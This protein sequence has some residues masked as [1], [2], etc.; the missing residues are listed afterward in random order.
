V[1]GDGAAAHL[2]ALRGLVDA[3]TAT[4]LETADGFDGDAAATLAEL[5]SCWYA[6]VHVLSICWSVHLSQSALLV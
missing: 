5:V 3:A 6:L 1:D 4:A 2:G